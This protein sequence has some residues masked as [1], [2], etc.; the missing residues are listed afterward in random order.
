ML[1]RRL[2]V[3]GLVLCP[4]FIP[5]AA[6]AA[7]PGVSD[8]R[9]VLGQ[10]AKLSGTSG[11]ELGRQYRDGLRLAFE[12]ANR[13]GGV[14]GR[15][16][17]LMSL[18][19]GNNA[20]TARANTRKLI[21]T[22]VFALVGYTF[23]GPVRAALP[24]A[25]ESDTPL[26]GPY[27]AMPE[28]YETAMPH[29]F[30]FRASVADELAAIVRHID[31]VGYQD[32]AMVHYANPLGDDVRKEVA[33]R[34]QATGRR[35]VATATMQITP[36]DSDEA[37]RPAVALMTTPA[38]PRVVFLGVSGRDAAAVVRGMAAKGCGSVRYFA[39]SLVDIPMLVKELGPAARGVMVTQVVPNPHRGAHP[40]VMDYR[41]QLRHRDPA[42]RPDFTEFEGFI[43]GRFI[44]QALLRSGPAPDRQR[45]MRAMESVTLE[46]PGRYRVHFGAGK[47]VGS[48]YTNFVMVSAAGRI[49]D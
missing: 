9:I 15:R 27:A 39:R 35:L 23:S 10:S 6:W 26:V 12:A 19:D 25:R 41:E 22:G 24:L 2:L 42:A 48:R 14:H 44:V 45:F 28:L 43:V 20:E 31:T 32:V 16:L 36:A 34:L 47:R 33:A 46:G 7:V 4:A 17:D 40:L 29:V 1:I 49:T 8:D 11:T 30:M 38:C 18:D 13:A 37:A 5:G 21:D 3:A